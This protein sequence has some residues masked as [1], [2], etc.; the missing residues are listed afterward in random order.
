MLALPFAAVLSGNTAEITTSDVRKGASFDNIKASWGK[1]LNI[2]NVKSNLRCNYDYNENKGFLKEVSLQG[3]LKESSGD[4]MSLSYD[5]NHNFNSKNTEVKLTANA[6][7]NTL[8][9]LGDTESNL[10]EVSLARS[11][12]AG[13]QSIDVEPSWLVQ[14]N[15]ARIKMMSALGGNDGKVSAQVDV[16]TDDRSTAY[17]VGYSRSVN[18]ADVSAT[19][20]SSDQSLDVEYVDSKFE[21][22]ATW[23][24]KLSVDTGDMADSKLD[25]A[26]LTL[27]RPWAW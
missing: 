9:V 8:S 25:A 2:G 20:A 4:D 26:K 19:Y 5:V 22:G 24:A 17:E 12:D 16:N 23:T 13:D 15:T 18:G 21:D 3:D 27:K 10:K 6:N 7:G 14:A 11:V 1:A